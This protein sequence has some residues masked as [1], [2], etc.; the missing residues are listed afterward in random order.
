MQGVSLDE[1][2]QVCTGSKA[3]HSTAY[4]GHMHVTI[5][6]KQIFPKTV[7]ALSDLGFIEF[8]LI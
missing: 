3:L 5:V 1:K 2:M 7:H 4:V 6:D 8:S